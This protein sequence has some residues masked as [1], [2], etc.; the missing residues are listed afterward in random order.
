MR[1]FHARIVGYTTRMALKHEIPCP[2]VMQ[3]TRSEQAEIAQSERRQ[4][5]HDDRRNGAAMNLGQVVA[6][7]AKRARARQTHPGKRNKR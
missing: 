2:D 1:S 3:M 5:R 6:H 4:R 7:A